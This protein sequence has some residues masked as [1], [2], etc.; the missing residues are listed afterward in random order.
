MGDTGIIVPTA[1]PQAF[2]EGIQ[3]L[4]SLKPS[5]RARLGAEARERIVKNYSFKKMV[6]AYQA[7]YASVPRAP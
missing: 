3:R 5:E 1:Q 6:D 4:A 7:L 2:S